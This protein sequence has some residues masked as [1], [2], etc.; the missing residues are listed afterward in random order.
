MKTIC[1][2]TGIKKAFIDNAISDF[3]EGKDMD[4]DEVKEIGINKI[5]VIY[6]YYCNN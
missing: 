3:N 1:D 2:S 6:G 4:E 5:N